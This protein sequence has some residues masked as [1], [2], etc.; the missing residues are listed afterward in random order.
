MK[1]IRLLTSGNTRKNLA[2]SG[3]P[4]GFRAFFDDSK[5]NPT[6]QRLGLSLRPARSEMA[7]TER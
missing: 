5:H 2:R 7:A 4:C 1:D 3:G 6:D